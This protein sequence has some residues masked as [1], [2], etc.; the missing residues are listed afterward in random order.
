[1]KLPFGLKKPSKGTVIFSG[2]AGAVSGI[3][4]VSNKKAEEARKINASK[5]S[6][7]ADRPCG[8]HEMPRKVLV[9]I[10]PPPGDSI[11][12]S[13]NWFREYVKPVLVAGAVDYEVKE[14]KEPGQIE[15]SVIEEIVKRRREDRASI[16][17]NTTLDNSN[18]N[19]KETT[20]P[21][22]AMSVN[23]VPEVSLK[24]EIYYDGILAIGRNAYKEVLSGFAKGCDAS[25]T[26]TENKSTGD[27]SAAATDLKEISNS[28]SESTDNGSDGA[29]EVSNEPLPVIKN[30]DVLQESHDLIEDEI[31]FS[32][33][34]KFSPVM[35]IPHVNIIGWSNIPFRLYMWY[36]DYKRIQDVGKYVVAAVLNQTRPIEPRDADLGQNE[37]KYWIG[38][39]E[40][41]E[42]KENDKPI[43]IDERIRDK[44]TTYTSDE[45]P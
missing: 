23:L 2:I 34:S 39:D 19:F 27:S 17:D 33:P 37:K 45:L 3:V 31:S 7:L 41:K 22:T 14:A 8:V 43:V 35:Y 20:T 44:L 18:G 5:V 21:T 36:A 1:M 29:E 38:D 42:L 40:V 32:L 25:L 16:V 30:E 28:S 13:R 15:N 6:F 26:V 4:Y 24:K 11:E 10:S 12:K 9:F